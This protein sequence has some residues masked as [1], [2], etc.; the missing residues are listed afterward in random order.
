MYMCV[1]IYIFIYSLYNR[2][3]LEGSND[4]IIVA[5]TRPETIFGDTGLAVNPNDTRY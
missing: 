2:Y 4:Y 3:P 5:T 1:C